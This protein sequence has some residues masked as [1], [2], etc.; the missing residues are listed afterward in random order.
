MST[1]FLTAHERTLAHNKNA[2]G[3]TTYRR[4]G[5]RFIK[6]LHVKDSSIMCSFCCQR[7]HLKGDCYVE[8][9]LNKGMRCMWLVRRLPPLADVGSL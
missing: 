5:L 4:S 2:H 7:G 6:P 8:R 9:N 3:F 1:T